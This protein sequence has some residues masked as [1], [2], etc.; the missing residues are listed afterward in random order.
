M[1]KTTCHHCTVHS[2][3]SV[4]IFF[5]ICIKPEGQIGPK[6]KDDVMWCSVSR[7]ASMVSIYYVQLKLMFVLSPVVQKPA[8][9]NLWCWFGLCWLPT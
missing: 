1:E 5:N 6:F 8:L 3:S 7:F 2:G 4:F 9:C